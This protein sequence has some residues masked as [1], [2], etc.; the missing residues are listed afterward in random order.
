MTDSSTATVD[1]AEVQLVPGRIVAAWQAKDAEAFAA[2]F[3]ED[4]SMILPG[5]VYLTGRRAIR[6]FMAEAFGG[7][8]RATQ[9]TGTPLAYK[10][11]AG[12][13]VLLL[14]E[15]GVLADGES[16]VSAANAIRASWLLRRV[17]ER[18]LITAYQNTPIA[19]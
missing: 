5:G 6:D 13:V 19:A 10:P 8:Y 9:V 3:T 12:D 11:L 17:D 7:P 14:T 15:G 2:A 4:G 1:P 18:W 16:E